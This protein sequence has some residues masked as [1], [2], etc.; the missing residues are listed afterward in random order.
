MICHGAGTH[1]PAGGQ[2]REH[3][4]HRRPCCGPRRRVGRPQTGRQSCCHACCSRDC[5]W[6]DRRA[7]QAC[8]AKGQGDFW[9]ASRQDCQCT[10]QSD[11]C[12]HS[13][14]STTWNK[15]S[16]THQVRIC[17][18]YED[19]VSLE[20]VNAPPIG[21]SYCRAW[22]PGSGDAQVQRKH[23][24]P[25]QLVWQFLGE[26]GGKR[27]CSTAPSAAAPAARRSP[28]WPGGLH[29]PC[30]WQGRNCTL[31]QHQ[32]AT[33]NRASKTSK[34]QQ[35]SPPNSLGSLPATPA[36]LLLLLCATHPPPL[37]KPAPL[38]R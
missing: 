3:E 1:E 2:A 20:G 19:S 18:R 25:L 9:Q 35:G 26:I 21:R 12:M 23:Q 4:T 38:M 13:C 27:N 11:Q 29:R 24:A 10:L 8:Q 31:R 22:W 16:S 37:P 30:T 14:R 32:R 7:R 15:Q 33:A 5:A 34:L 17:V 6:R 28:S 36:A